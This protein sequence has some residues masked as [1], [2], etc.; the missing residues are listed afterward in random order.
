MARPMPLFAPVTAAMRVYAMLV[1]EG[2][3]KGRVGRVGETC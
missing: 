2:W 1:F 3:R